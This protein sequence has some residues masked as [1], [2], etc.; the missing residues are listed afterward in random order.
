MI[1][2]DQTERLAE[3]FRDEGIV[4][5]ASFLDDEHALALHGNLRERGDWRQ[6]FNSGDKLFELDRATRAGM[7]AAR[8]TQLDDAIYSGARTGFQYRYETVRVA[9]DEARRIAANDPI[10]DFALKMSAGSTREFL[11]KVTGV[12][13][14]E[15]AD[16]QATAFSPG[17]FLTGHDDDFPGKNRHAAYVMSLTPTWRVE[18]GGLLLMHGDGDRPARAYTPSA[19][20]LTIFRVGQMH[21]VTEVTRAAAYRRYA[22]TGWLRS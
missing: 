2:A 15:F 18:W 3:R 11:R 19:N 8:R 20:V 9:D 21:S 17:D 13:A 22:I 10:A 12:D 6:V 16:A 5:I 4:R 7:D 14:I 1:T